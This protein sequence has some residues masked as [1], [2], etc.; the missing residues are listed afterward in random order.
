MELDAAREALANVTEIDWES[1]TI[2]QLE[3][4]LTGL[5]RAALA[6]ATWHEGDCGTEACRHLVATVRAEVELSLAT[7]MLAPASVALLVGRV[8]A[9]LAL[10]VG[11]MERRGDVPTL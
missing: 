6:L 11:H 4:V 3:L 7:S 5:E 10:L 8:G 9:V 1:A 2:G